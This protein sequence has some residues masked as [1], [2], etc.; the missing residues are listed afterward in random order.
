MDTRRVLSGKSFSQLT[1]LTQLTLFV[2]SNLSVCLSIHPDIDS[3]TDLPIP[4][5]SLG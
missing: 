2:R 3:F 5:F 1:A 4:P